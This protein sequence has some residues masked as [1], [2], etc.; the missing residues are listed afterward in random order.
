VK[1]GQIEEKEAKRGEIK[2]RKTKLERE[3]PEKEKGGEERER[4]KQL[5]GRERERRRERGEKSQFFNFFFIPSSLPSLK[6]KSY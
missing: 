5:W 4:E 3:K 2:K 6:Y 1:L